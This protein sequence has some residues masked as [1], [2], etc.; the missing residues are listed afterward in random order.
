MSLNYILLWITGG[1]CAAT[2]ARTFPSVN[3][4]GRGW[5]MV[6]LFTL[7]VTGLAAIVDADYAGYIG[8]ILWLALIVAPSTASR[9]L[10][11]AIIAQNFPK[12]RALAKMAATLHPFD[13]WQDQPALIEAI[14]KAHKSGPEEAIATLRPFLESNAP[15]AGV[16]AASYFRINGRWEEALAWLRVHP[17]SFLSDPSLLLLYIRALGETGDIE[18]MAQMLMSGHALLQRTPSFALYAKLFAFAFT[19]RKVMLGRLLRDGRLK[20][21]PAADAFWL[22][23]AEMACGQHRAGVERLQAVPKTSSLAW[24]TAIARRMSHPLRVVSGRLSPTTE[25]RIARLEAEYFEEESY[26]AVPSAKYPAGARNDSADPG[27]HR[28]VLRRGFERRRDESFHALRTWSFVSTGGAA[29]G[30]ASRDCF[31]VP[32][33]RIS[34]SLTEH[35]RAPCARPLRR[36]HR[37]RPPLSPDLCGIWHRLNAAHRAHQLPNRACG[38]RSWRVWQHYGN[39]GRHG[40]HIMAR[41]AA[42]S[43]ASRAAAP[44][45]SAADYR[46]SG[47]VR[48]FHAGGQFSGT[49]FRRHY[50]FLDSPLH[51]DRT[52]SLAELTGARDPPPVYK[53]NSWTKVAFPEIRSGST[54]SGAPP[55]LS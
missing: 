54:R 25:A 51:D 20:L 13:G 8:G 40:R 11:S 36:D 15:T 50:R 38:S 42:I 2:L 34:S 45:G 29:W 17:V 9:L 12:A 5:F 26:A 1:S 43:L 33:L 19:G 7:V 3:D 46:L 30:M 48:F 24:Q 49:F 53:G 37:G 16:A 18:G 44:R 35:A 39:R 22:A 32:S 6:S 23:T 14:E 10:S 55:F 21:P 52:G 47:H 28:R 41:V 27:E 31:H 4:T